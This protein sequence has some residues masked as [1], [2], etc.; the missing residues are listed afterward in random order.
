MTSFT[1][2][3]PSPRPPAARLVH[4]FPLTSF[5]KLPLLPRPP[6]LFPTVLLLLNPKF[7]L[8]GDSITE[9]ASG[10]TG[11]GTLLGHYHSRKADVLNRGYSGYN[12]KHALAMLRQFSDIQPAGASFNHVL[13]TIFFGANDACD[14]DIAWQGVPL[15]EY[16]AN[17]REMVALLKVKLPGAAVRE[18]PISVAL[19]SY[20]T[21]AIT[22]CSIY[23]HSTL[24]WNC[25]SRA[26]LIAPFWPPST[27]DCCHRPST[28]RLESQANEVDEA[29]N[30]PASG[31]GVL[32]PASSCPHEAANK[33]PGP[34]LTPHT[35]LVRLAC[36]LQR[37]PSRWQRPRRSCM[38]I[39]IPR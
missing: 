21:L 24:P 13:V 39:L 4:L 26:R 33:L 14:R 27:P 32:G 37:Q 29:E 3:P 36:S 30:R 38:S 7:W 8:F 9:R 12:S 28:V 2:A 17:M 25:A 23:G 35:T 15:P 5:L 6:H 11:W 16:E 20:P 34:P 31:T 22:L 18:G 19:Q 1:Q 10:P